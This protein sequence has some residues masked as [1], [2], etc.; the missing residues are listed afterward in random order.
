MSISLTLKRTV[1][2][3]A[4]Q[5]DQIRRLFCCVFAREMSEATFE[6]RFMCT[7]KGYSYHG[8]M[9]HDDRIVGSFTAIPYRYRY[10]GKEVVFALSVD[11]MID[12]NYRGDKTRLP[13]MANLV[14]EMLLKDDIP[15][16]Y[17]F[18]NEYYYNHEK[19]ILGTKDIGK[20]N[21]Y[22]LP[23][24]I[25]SVLG[26]LRF[27][28]SLSRIVCSAFLKFPAIKFAD[29]MVYNIEKI[30][31]EA[32]QKHRYDDS[33][34][35]VRFS[36]GTKCVYRSYIEEKNVQTLYILDVSPLTPNAFKETVKYIYEERAKST[37]IMIYVGS[38]SFK[39]YGLVKVPDS[40]EPQKI[41]M[42]GKILNHDVVNESVLDLKNW[43]VNISNFDVR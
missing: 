26:K 21:Y 34:I 16:I 20:L 40:M 4:E 24:N 38:L 29:K 1:D 22:I 33:Y 6:R 37:D 9:L 3:S 13:K 8:L 14:Y 17:G 35:T 31:D 5:R 42:T 43:A 32:F 39:P 27:L 18:P 23:R 30:D 15:F 7:P 12:S 10:F 28:N 41:R 11:T 25:G 36:S 2:L 19:R